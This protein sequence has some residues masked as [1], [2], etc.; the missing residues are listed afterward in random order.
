MSFS[1][2]HLQPH[3][4]RIIRRQV[5][6]L[7]QK[8][9]D[10][11]GRVFM[12]RPNPMI[13]QHLPCVLVYLNEEPAD[14][15][16]TAPRIYERKANFIIEI[17]YEEGTTVKE[18]EEIEDLLDSRSYEVEYALLND[19]ALEMGEDGEWIQDV[20]LISSIT[21]KAIYEGQAIVCA[22]K[23]LYEI[24]YETEHYTAENL[25]QFLRFIATYDSVEGA[26]A[27]DNVTIRER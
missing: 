7:L 10:V 19:I 20:T 9:V 1:T 17:L 4:R 22:L 2:Q 24:T 15:Q 25:D 6:S 14:H 5:K 13:L 23:Q 12:C 3:Y 16:N 8:Y 26:N 11:S 27:T 21:S 18:N